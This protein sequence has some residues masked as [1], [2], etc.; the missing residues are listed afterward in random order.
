[1][2]LPKP[3]IVVLSILAGLGAILGWALYTPKGDA[4][5]YEGYEHHG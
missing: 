3:L 1:M 5:S 2:M 4:Y